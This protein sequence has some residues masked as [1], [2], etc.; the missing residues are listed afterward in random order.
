VL[1]QNGL[2][3]EQVSE[4]LDISKHTLGSWKKLLFDT[5]SLDKK[6]VKRKSGTPY[7]YTP[8]KIKEHLD[9]S[10]SKSNTEDSPKDSKAQTAQMSPKK[11][12]GILQ[13]SVNSVTPNDTKIQDE[14]KSKKKKKNKFKF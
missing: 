7:K 6:I 8:D 4:K 5:G 2:S 9:K 11:G 13:M 1:C 12:N 14:Q 10:K 3:D